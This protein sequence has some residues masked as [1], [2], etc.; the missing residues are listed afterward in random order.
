M[1]GDLIEMCIELVMAITE[2][3]PKVGGIIIL[4]IGIGVG[5]YFIFFH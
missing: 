5:V 1:D 4:T 2:S 3:S